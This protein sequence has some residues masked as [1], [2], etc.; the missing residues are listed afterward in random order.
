MNILVL[1]R[2]FFPYEK[3]KIIKEGYGAEWRTEREI[4]NSLILWF[5]SRTVNRYL[6]LAKKVNELEA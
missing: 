5:T 1:T 3:Q 6:E 2:Y 4:Y